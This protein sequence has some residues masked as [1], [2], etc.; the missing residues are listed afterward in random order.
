ML[1][2]AALLAG[3]APTLAQRHE[4]A[5][6]SITALQ[7]GAFDDAE[8]EAAKVVAA[9]AENPYALLVRAIAHYKRSM[10]QLVLDLRTTFLGAALVR[11]LNT[12]YL[13]TTVTA[14]EA[15]L[16]AVEADLAVAARSKGVS[17]ELCLACWEIDWNG[18]GQVDEKD[19]KLLQIEE[20]ADGQ[21][22]PSE[23]PRRKPTFRFDDGD[24]QWARAFVSFQRAVLD[25]ALAFDW[26]AV[27]QLLARQEP[28]QLA[29][30]LA[31]PERIAQAK[32]RTLEGLDL[33]DLA[34]QS[35]LAETDD[36]R[37]W[38]PNPNQKSHPI[39]LPV[40]ASLYATWEALVG[41][42]RRLVR[43]E[44]GLSLAELAHL[45]NPKKP[46]APEG[47][48]DLGEM[49]DHPRD[50]SID[51]AALKHADR[52]DAA[53]EA[54]AA[55][56]GPSYLHQMKPSPMVGRLERI[57]GEVERHQESIERKLHYLLW[58]N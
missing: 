12:R 39:P 48:L 11:G 51:V 18:N 29:F 46:G 22:I 43:G 19:R 10:H 32:A 34:R 20:D 35:Y 37:E 6:T 28:A 54:I 21:P 26:S 50:I 56:L 3:C 15:D 13:E 33:S 52:A 55:I 58:V 44:E 16:A 25:V 4:A 14:A 42:L 5:T 45:A 36:D 38:L 17:L 53:G 30:P 31:H 7:R 57:K 24:V 27:N 47:C 8:R 23:D 9:D 2:L 40:D 41:D 49:L 1:F